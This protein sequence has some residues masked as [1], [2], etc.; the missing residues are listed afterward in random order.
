VYNSQ[1]PFAGT[2]LPPGK[3]LGKRALLV[4]H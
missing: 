1:R 4:V 3:A 2:V